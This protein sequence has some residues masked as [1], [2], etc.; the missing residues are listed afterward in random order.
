MVVCLMGLTGFLWWDS[1]ALNVLLGNGV[2]EEA[3]LSASQLT[4][5][6]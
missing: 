3:G 5:K 2:G 1:L 6:P 4:M